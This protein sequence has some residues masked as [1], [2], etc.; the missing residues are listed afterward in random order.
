MKKH[1]IMIS[2][3]ISI[4]A[5]IAL[6]SCNSTPAGGGGGSNKNS[7]SSL[8]GGG[9]SSTGGGGASSTGGGS[10]NIMGVFS[11]THTANLQPIDDVSVF[12][13]VWSTGN[14]F[15]QTAVSNSAPEGAEY[16]NITVAGGVG[17]FG[18]GWCYATKQ[19]LSAYSAG[20]IHL[21]LK[22]TK[23]GIQVG[24][25]GKWSGTLTAYGYLADGA[26]HDVT[27]PCSS[28]SG[29]TWT[30]VDYFFEILNLG[31]CVN[32]DVYGIDDVYFTKN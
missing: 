31:S 4:A 26:W 8:G 11:E 29:V 19:D 3:L 5:L 7:A 18:G 6:A 14:T 9:A 23:D 2:V 12:F 32:G 1:F 13:Y 10:G 20:H 27:V 30:A 25:G 21:K 28:L 15:V 16:W 17:W 24:V 22:G